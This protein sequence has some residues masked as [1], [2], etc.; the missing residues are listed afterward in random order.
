MKTP[1]KIIKA[2]YDRGA[3]LHEIAELTSYSLSFIE[4]TLQILGQAQEDRRSRILVL[5]KRETLPNKAWVKSNEIAKKLIKN[6]LVKSNLEDWENMILLYRRHDRP[7][8]ERFSDQLRLEVFLTGIKNA[9]NGK[10]KLLTQ[11]MDLESCF[12]H[13]NSEISLEEE[14]DFIGENFTEDLA[15]M[16]RDNVGYFREDEH[17]RWRQPVG[18]GDNGGIIVDSPKE[19][20]KREIARNIILPKRRESE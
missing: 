19:M 20:L 16:R 14:K 18:F 2:L 6:N 10:H 7:L 3:H 4:E 13:S 12:D 11:L 1:D 5:P 9:K 15:G 17:G 8:P